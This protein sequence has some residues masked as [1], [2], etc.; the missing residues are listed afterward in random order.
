MKLTSEV[1]L[2]IVFLLAIRITLFLEAEP[3]E[4]CLTKTRR[5]SHLVDVAWRL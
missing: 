1:P 4:L 3:E 5:S 2:F